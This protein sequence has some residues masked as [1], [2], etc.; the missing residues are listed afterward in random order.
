VNNS[1]LEESQTYRSRFVARVPKVYTST[2][3]GGFEF[4]STQYLGVGD[5]MCHAQPLFDSLT[6]SL[7]NGFSAPERLRLRQF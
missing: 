6:D 3:K 7:T 5:A 2:I 1:E 4:K